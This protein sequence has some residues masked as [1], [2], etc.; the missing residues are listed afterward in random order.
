MSKEGSFDAFA[1]FD[2]FIN[3]ERDDNTNAYKTEDLNDLEYFTALEVG[4]KCRKSLPEDKARSLWAKTMAKYSQRQQEGQL[5]VRGRKS[6]E[7]KKTSSEWLGPDGFHYT[8]PAEYY[9]KK[10]REQGYEL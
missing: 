1:S 9:A 8:C 5:P 6:I 7:N 3:L 4:D 2:K 10:L